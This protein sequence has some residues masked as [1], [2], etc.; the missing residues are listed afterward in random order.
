MTRVKIC[1]VRAVEHALV[2]AEAGAQ[3]V[4]VICWPGSKRYAPPERVRE[5]TN[6]L[7]AGF[8]YQ[9]RPLVTGVF[10][11]EPAPNINAL[12]RDCALDC[13]QLSGD[14]PW[15]AFQAIDAPVLK[16]LRV[17]SDRAE[18]GLLTELARE[19]PALH[20]RAGRVLMEALVTGQYGGTGQTA[21]WNL[22]AAAARRFPLLLSGGL[23]PDNVAAAVRTVRP[24]GV[25]VASGVETD[26]VQDPGKIRAFIHAVQQADAAA[27]VLPA[28]VR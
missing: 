17:P 16:A 22:A 21:N 9:R 8:D 27:R 11:N 2:A 5:I 10:V 25:D 15:D 18:A 19:T 23:K 12:V 14:E 4:G 28:G 6:A 7:R 20:Q 26:G 24:W 1:G 3:Y 13:V